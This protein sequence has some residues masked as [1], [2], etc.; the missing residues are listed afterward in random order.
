[1]IKHKVIYNFNGYKWESEKSDINSIDKK[2]LARMLFD[3]FVINEFESAVLK[4]KNE[5]CVW[6]PVHTSIGQEAVAAASAAA[7]K[8]S[9]KF[10]GTHRSHHQFLSKLLKY[11]VP[12]AW[13]PVSDKLPSEAETV[14]R[15]TL[16]E[17]MGLADG[18]C[19]GR[20]GSM[21]LR[22][23]MAGFY[24]SNAIVAGGIPLATGTAFTEKYNNTGNVVVCFFGDGAINQGAFHEACNLAGLWKLPVIF[25]LENNEYAVATKVNSSCA[26]S[27]LSIRAASYGMEAHIVDGNDAVAIYHINEFSCRRIRKNNRPCF[28]EAKCYR[29]YHH[30]GD[31]PGSAFKYRSKEEEDIWMKKEVVVKFA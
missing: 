25:F 10:F 12:D 14:V 20:G 5:D 15:R 2:I 22:D 7:L 11:Y 28:V 30:A 31:Q 6:G 27:E 3:V 4:L 1:M 17:I 8:S 29:R 24:G 13:D 26:V 16:A 23:K 19:G 9:D 21:H 18:Y